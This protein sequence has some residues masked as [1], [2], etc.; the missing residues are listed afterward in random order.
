LTIFQNEFEGIYHFTSEKLTFSENFE[1]KQACQR[2]N[3]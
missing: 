3:Q 2:K 1:T